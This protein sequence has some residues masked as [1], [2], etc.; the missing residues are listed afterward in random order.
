MNLNNADSQGTSEH[1]FHPARWC[2]G[3]VGNVFSA[4]NQI[5]CGHGGAGVVGCDDTDNAAPFLHAGL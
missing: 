1:I 4:S 2:S 5:S 3:S